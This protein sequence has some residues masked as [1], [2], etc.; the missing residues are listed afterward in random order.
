[1]KVDFQFALIT[2]AVPAVQFRLG[3]EQVHLARSAVLKKADNGLG[4]GRMMRH[5]R[6]E[7]IGRRLAE[8]MF[9]GEEVSQRQ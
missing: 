5:A 9:L 7:R 4:L 2:S 8:S 1:M 6:R 3:I